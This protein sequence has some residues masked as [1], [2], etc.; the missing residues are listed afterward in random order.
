MQGFSARGISQSWGSPTSREGRPSLAAR[1]GQVS[2]GAFF[3]NAH[4]CEFQPSSPGFSRL[5]KWQQR[6]NSFRICSRVE[7]DWL[8]FLTSRMIDNQRSTMISLIDFKIMTLILFFRVRRSPYPKAAQC[9]LSYQDKKKQRSWFCLILSSLPLEATLIGSL[10]SAAGFCS[11]SYPQLYLVDYT[12]AEL[13]RKIC[14]HSLVPHSENTC[15]SD[16]KHHVSH[17][18]RI[19]LR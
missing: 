18:F 7:K 13:H 5:L 10:P 6:C 8:M 14:L 17:Y 19:I 16:N 1:P 2:I 11:S 12:K 4:F 15:N 3:K 9:P